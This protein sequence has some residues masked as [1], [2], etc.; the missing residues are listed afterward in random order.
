MCKV[1]NN[2]LF[3]QSIAKVLTFFYKEKRLKTR[4]ARHAVQH[5]RALGGDSELS[6]D[7]EDSEFSE[8]SDYSDYSKFFYCFDCFEGF[9]LITFLRLS[10]RLPLPSGER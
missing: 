3:W 7:S 2:F 1:T 6:E 10:R 8:Y 5:E 4:K 9:Q